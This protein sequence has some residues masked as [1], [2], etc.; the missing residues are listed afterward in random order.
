MSRFPRAEKSPLQKQLP[1]LELLCS[2]T[3][4]QLTPQPSRLPGMGPRAPQGTWLTTQRS[5]PA[6]CH[7]GRALQ[8]TAQS[9]GQGVQAAA[10]SGLGTQEQQ[11]GRGCWSGSDLN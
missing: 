8:G 10:Q 11:G 7:R 2:S 3:R 9:F 6:L 5:P 1:V 4:R